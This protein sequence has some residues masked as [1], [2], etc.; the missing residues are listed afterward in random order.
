MTTTITFSGATSTTKNNPVHVKATIVS[1]AVIKN[2]DW[3]CNKPVNFT[4]TIDKRTLNFTPSED[5]EYIF[6]CW[7][8]GAEEVIL[9]KT[10]KVI[11]GTGTTTPPPVEPTEPP[12]P[13][14]PT[15]GTLIYD[16]NVDIDWAN[17]NNKVI[18]IGSPY[19]DVTKPGKKYIRM[20][21]SGD[22][23]ITFLSATKELVLQHNGNYGRAYF[24]VLN[25]ACRIEIEFKLDSCGANLSLKSRNRHQYNEYL[26]SIGQEETSDQNKLQGGQGCSVS[27][28]DTD[29]DLEKSHDT[30]EVSGPSGSI[31]P[32]LTANKY[33]GLR[34]SQYDLNGK[35]HV[36]VELDRKDEAGF[37][38]INEGDVAAPSQFFNKTDFATFS[39]FWVRYNTSGGKLYFKN[40]K[41]YAL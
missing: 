18:K 14:I 33:Y 2:V 8:I 19:G 4:V 27:C 41:V 25:Y 26:R 31:S 10:V 1:D 6:T 34:F 17:W 3:T 7:V 5:G 38:K 21:A 20:N 29:A 11:C 24:G 16:S 9:A 36:L 39:E 35:I 13:P 28:S 32:G 40:L 15:S 22:P 23:N 37:K 30:G 12:I